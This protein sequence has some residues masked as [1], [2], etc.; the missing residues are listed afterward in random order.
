M[1]VTVSCV[2]SVRLCAWNNSAPIGPIFMRFDILSIFRKSVNEV[3]FMTIGRVLYMKTYIH[4]LIISRSV[5]I[6]M[7]SV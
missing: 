5:L 7:L 3:S 4:F 6:G 2:M 1:D